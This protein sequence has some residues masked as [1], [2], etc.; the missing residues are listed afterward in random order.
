MITVAP[1]LSASFIIMEGSFCRFSK[2]AFSDRDIFDFVAFGSVFSCWPHF[3]IDSI[4]TFNCWLFDFGRTKCDLFFTNEVSL[5]ISFP[6]KCSKR[7]SLRLNS[8]RSDSSSG[9]FSYGV[10]VNLSP[11]CSSLISQFERSLLE[12][13][14]TFGSTTVFFRSSFWFD[15]RFEVVCETC[16]VVVCDSDR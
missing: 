12:M 5:F 6:S 14:M 10:G 1:P 13:F 3:E 8:W 4:T 7:R 2:G 15:G 16:L 9:L 11:L